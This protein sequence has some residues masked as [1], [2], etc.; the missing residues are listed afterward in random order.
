MVE[1]H[2][3]TGQGLPEPGGFQ[4]AREAAPGFVQRDIFEVD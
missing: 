4:R 1:R 2:G 3:L